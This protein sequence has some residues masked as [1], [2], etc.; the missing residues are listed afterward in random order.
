[1]YFMYVD[2]SGDVGLYDANK[3]ERYRASPHY[4]VSGFIVPADEWR[5]YLTAFYNFR[6]FVKRNY[7][8]PV[9]EELHGISL[10]NPRKSPTHQAIGIRRKRIALYQQTLIATCNLMPKARIINVH[11]NKQNPVYP[12]TPTPEGIL[13]HVWSRLLERYHTFLVK[14]CNSDKGLIFADE[15]DE[16][17]LRRL[18][19]KMRVFNFAGS[20]YG[21]GY[22]YPLTQL[23]EDPIMRASE[24]SYFV[25]I[26]DMISHALYRKLYPKGS[27]RTYNVD[28]L[29]DHVRPLLHLPASSRDPHRMGIVHC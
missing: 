28:K 22:S 13:N 8:L 15:N 3:P 16:V 20:H 11:L 23:L 18:T 27:L 5:S 2:E 4:I 21:G 14:S 1:M 19:R 17:R 25:Q 29:F 24:N 10:I 6:R 7:G 12:Y 9:H 26:S